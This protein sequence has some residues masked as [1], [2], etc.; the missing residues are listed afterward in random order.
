MA[1]VMLAIDW[2]VFEALASSVSVVLRRLLISA[3]RHESLHQCRGLVEYLLLALHSRS[4]R[5]LY[6]SSIGD[7]NVYSQ[8]LDIVVWAT[9]VER[10]CCIL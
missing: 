2:V 4:N 5:H 10:A 9:E 7:P 6:T 3:C 8:K 1:A